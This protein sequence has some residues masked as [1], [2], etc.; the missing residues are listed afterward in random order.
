MQ[1]FEIGA[2]I[3]LEGESV[4]NSY[5][6]TYGEPPGDVLALGV[7]AAA[8]FAAAAEGVFLLSKCCDTFAL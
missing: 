2:F 7:I 5:S 1:P 3:L 8:S 4:A 6:L